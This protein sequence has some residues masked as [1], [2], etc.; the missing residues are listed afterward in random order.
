V[1]PGLSLRLFLALLLAVVPPLVAL[2]ALL[3][4]ARSIG[5]QASAAVLGSTTILLTIGW[6][7][8]LTI[9]LGRELS[10][11]QRTL[12]SLA[13]RGEAKGT[14]AEAGLR[15]DHRRLAASLEERNRQVAELASLA[16]RAP[17]RDSPP[18]V[19]A[20]VVQATRSILRDPTWRLAVLDSGMPDLLPPGVYG[21]SD[22]A[23]AAPLSDLERWAAT[24]ERDSL[25][26]GRASHVEGAW[27]AFT[28][29]PVAAEVEL[30]AVLY[31]PWEGRPV[32]TA[33]ETDLITL[34]AQEAATVLEHSLLYARL[35]SQTDELNRMAGVQADFL[36]GITHDLQTPL[37]SIAALAAELR[38][39]G[40]LPSAAHEDL[41]AIAHGA[42]RLRRMVGQLLAVSRLEAGALAPRQEVFS[43]EPIVRRVWS[44]LRAEH[45]FELVRDGASQL[46]V[47]DPDRL[48]QVLWAVFDNA[49]KYSPP[50]AGILVRL[51]PRGGDR[52]A[53]T[54]T[55]QGTGMD[56]ETRRRA[57]E[58]FYRSD[59]AR[60]LA[61]DGSG[62][63]LFAVQGL[64]TAM[65]GTVEIESRLGDGTTVSLI[66]PAE[67][68][69]P[70]AVDQVPSAVAAT[71]RRAL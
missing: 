41:D 10:R 36:R 28:V 11:E 24:A 63:G 1:V 45:G 67:A 61:P 25:R 62:I 56:E 57:F 38:A 3:L 60:S 42:D 70:D 32:P 47:A 48:E 65:G 20:H 37:T 6:A 69:Q 43:P 12:V 31:A 35:R 34:V 52:L 16:S 71:P 7:A 8:I 14:D 68:A 39:E 23:G 51:A 50:S 55:D 22:E 53:I 33:A 40:R 64:M 17:M 4:V 13:E 26:E 2:I 58:Q 5:Q 66:L 59:A 46:V 18:E 44:A 21:S 54:I 29:V 19:A 30:R 49:V 9:A 27:G 15:A